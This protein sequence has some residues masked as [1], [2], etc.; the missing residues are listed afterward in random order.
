MCRYAADSA[1]RKNKF[2]LFVMQGVNGYYLLSVLDPIGVPI[3]L[4]LLITLGTAI[5][6]TWVMCKL[7]E[8]FSERNNT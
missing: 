6:V 7:E 4:V 2:L 5:V 3:I 8:A 1:D